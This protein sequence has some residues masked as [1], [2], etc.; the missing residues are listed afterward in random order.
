MKLFRFMSKEEFDKFIE[1][2]KLVNYKDHNK[3]GQKTNSI[4]FC[5]L[6]YA[7]YKPEE[8]LHSLTN[9]VSM[10]TCCIFETKRENVRRTYGRYSK[11]INKDSF[12]RTTIIAHEYCTTE[13]SKETFTLLKYAIPDWYNWEEWNW[14]EIKNGRSN[15]NCRKKE[16]R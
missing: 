15:V 11:A 4:G 13:Y 16:W 1:G 10:D 14:R 3:E 7:Q 6:N 8:M 12:E 5:F 2:E 9:I